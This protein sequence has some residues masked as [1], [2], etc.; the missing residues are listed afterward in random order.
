[1]TAF[2]GVLAYGQTREGLPLIDTRRD[3]STQLF[4]Y[5]PS[6]LGEGL[7]ASRLVRPHQSR[8]SDC[9]ESRYKYFIFS[10]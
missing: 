1:M 6:P 10:E 4:A 5:I 2:P 9:L 3:K 7:Y 8:R